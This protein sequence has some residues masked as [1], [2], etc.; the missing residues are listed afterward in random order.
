MTVIVLTS[1]TSWTVPGDFSATN[2]IE[3]WGA[4]GGGQSHVFIAD[5]D[6]GGGGGGY[7]AITNLGG[8]SGSIAITLGIGGVGETLTA[9]AAAGTATFFNGASLATSS[10]GA[11]G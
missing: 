10:V 7:S 5:D 2:T 6:C 11:N 8:L 1:G 3:T 9:N 4:G